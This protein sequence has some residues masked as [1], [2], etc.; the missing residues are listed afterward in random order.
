VDDT[1]P[2]TAQRIAVLEAHP[3]RQAAVRFD[4]NQKDELQ[5]ELA[6]AQQ[7]MQAQIVRAYAAQR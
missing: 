1:H 4:R 7:Q 2:S 5:R 3:V 6:M